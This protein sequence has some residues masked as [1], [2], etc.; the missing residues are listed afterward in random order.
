MIDVLTGQL[1]SSV[2]IMS[3]DVILSIDGESVSNHNLSSILK[4]KIGKRISLTYRRGQQQSAVSLQC[5]S[6]SC[7]MGI[8]MEDNTAQEILP[9]KYPLRKAM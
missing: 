5:P 4:T 8:L 2:G 1:A 6:S 7:I 9:I 3:G